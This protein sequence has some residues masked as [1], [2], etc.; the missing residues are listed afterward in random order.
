VIGLAL[1]GSYHR[2]RHTLWEQSARIFRS[3]VGLLAL[4]AVVSLF[5]QLQPSRSY[6]S[7]ALFAVVACSLLVRVGLVLLFNVLQRIGIGVERLILVGDGS[8]TTAA[9]RSQFMTTAARRTRVVSEVVSAPGMTAATI[10]GDVK[11]LVGRF[12]ATSVIVCGDQGM[13]VGLSRTIAAELGGSGVSVVIAPGAAEAVGPGVS[14]HPVGDLFLLRVRDSQPGFVE[15]CL[16]FL[17]DRVIAAVALVLL[18]PIFCVLAV[19]I[20]RDSPGPILFRQDRM[21]F[22]GRPFRIYKF[23]TM[24][25]DAE[26]RLRRDGL[27][28]AYVA[29][30][31]KLPQGEDPR[32]TPL[33]AKLRRTSLDELP[34]LWN[35]L[36]GSMSLV[37]PRPVVPKELEEY[38]DLRGAYT[39]VRP[40]VTGYWQ[41]NGRSD[42]GFPERGELDAYYYDNRSLRVDLRILCRTVI[43]VLARVGAH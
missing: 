30:G 19:L 36:T 37:G 29:N 3:A 5:L 13:P 2:L 35:V 14:L 7:I 6:V 8:G 18:S 42:V 24:V 39:G 23:R 21:G 41:V 26:D 12:G 28:D 34:Q 22:R 32:I 20:R 9:L 17:L 27:W 10:A 16:K 25:M 33:G 38:G 43:A 1:C 15:R 4:L 11:D 31:F 40:G